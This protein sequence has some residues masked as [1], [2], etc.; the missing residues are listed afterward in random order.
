MCACNAH[1]YTH[2]HTQCSP[3][4]SI[5]W[6]CYCACPIANMCQETFSKY[7]LSGDGW[8]TRY[9]ACAHSS[10][11]QLD[12]LTRMHFMNT[13]SQTSFSST[14]WHH[15]T[16]QTFLSQQQKKKD[17][18]QSGPQSWEMILLIDPGPAP[19][20]SS[21]KLYCVFSIG[22]CCILIFHSPNLH[23]TSCHNVPTIIFSYLI[24][25]T[26]A[27]SLTS[28]HKTHWRKSIHMETL[29]HDQILF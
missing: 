8:Y 16:R 28:T 13:E 7:M 3:V 25:L 18:W 9:T 23:L 4:Y 12:T 26:S 15:H 20:G 10:D 14:N 1:A 19:S 22:N 11:W 5:M 6:Q 24:L 17:K 2:A 29:H 21:I 27:R